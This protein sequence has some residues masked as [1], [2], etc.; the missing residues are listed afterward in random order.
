[1][2]HTETYTQTVA[3]RSWDVL[4][5]AAITVQGSLLIVND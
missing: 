4:R 5:G 3:C 2:P 1:M